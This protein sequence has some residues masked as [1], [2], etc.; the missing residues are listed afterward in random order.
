LGKFH[1]ALRRLDHVRVAIDN[2]YGVPATLFARDEVPIEADAVEQAL[3][4]M[5]V[6]REL[7][8]LG[9]GARLRRAVFTPDFHK[10]GG[11]PVGTVL[12]A[13][14][15]VLPQAVGSDVNCGMRLVVTDVTA[16]EL[17]PRLD[18]LAPALRAIYF[19]GARDVPTSPRQREAILREGMMGLLGAFDDNADRGL[20]RTVDRARAE[21]ELLSITFHGSLPTRG[22]FAFDDWARGS[23][24]TEGRDAQLGAIGGGNHFVELQTV[25]DVVDGTAARALGVERDRVAIMVHSGSVGLGHAVGGFFLDE[26]KRLWPTTHKRPASGFFP[27]F[28]DGPVA[29]RYLDAM[30][31]A[32]NFAFANR[33]VLGLMAVR[34]LGDV[35]GRAVEARLVWDAPHNLVWEPSAARS[36]YVHRKGACP[37]PGPDPSAA[38]ARAWL[39]APVILPGSMGTASWLL[40]GGGADEALESASHGAGRAIPRGRARRLDDSATNEALAR[41]RVVTPID[42]EAPSVRRRR[43]ILEQH[44]LRLREEAPTAYK[45]VAPVVGT[46]AAA[47]IARP[48]ARLLPLITVKAA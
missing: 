33:F 45:D 34:A 1:P 36:T 47:G 5:S 26:A 20:W 13:D 14:G 38:G 25:D 24:R 3:G 35:L 15:F 31:N 46:V 42:P 28:T 16:A 10:G 40:A 7:D 4:V 41:L 17:A 21:A 39:G 32:A 44:A 9:G 37:A 27:L 48:V 43:D 23:G 2:P 12:K 18:A 8:A 6:Q 11:I 19:G 22:T 30:R 29:A